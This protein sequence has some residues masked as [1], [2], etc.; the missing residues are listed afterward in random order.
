[1]EKVPSLIAV[2]L[3]FSLFWNQLTALSQGCL[4]MYN[5][6]LDPTWEAFFSEMCLHLYSPNTNL[7]PC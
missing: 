4:Y 1:M 2:S 7:K 5:I 6:F 3:S